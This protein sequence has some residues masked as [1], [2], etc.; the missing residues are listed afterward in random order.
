MEKGDRVDSGRQLDEAV[1]LLSMLE[2]LLGSLSQQMPASASVPWTG[3]MA[4]LRN[5]RETKDIGE[6]IDL[7]AMLE[8]L[9][10]SVSQQN[11]SLGLAPW[12]GVILT[13]RN[14][15]ETLRQARD[16]IAPSHYM[17]RPNYVA[18]QESGRTATL[19]DRVKQIPN[20][21]SRARELLSNVNSPAGKSAGSTSGNAADTEERSEAVE[22]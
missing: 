9:F 5:S 15:K 11:P 8:Y 20:T 16:V 10:G 14:C 19:A 21:G 13:L 1:S 18:Q 4:T 6:A 7:L 12:G 17:P 22:H 2:Y 3:M